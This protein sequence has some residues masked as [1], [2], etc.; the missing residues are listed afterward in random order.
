MQ[1]LLDP[2]YVGFS[3]E[4]HGMLAWDQAYV[5]GCVAR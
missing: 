2:L 5:D 1:Q 4:L 3:L